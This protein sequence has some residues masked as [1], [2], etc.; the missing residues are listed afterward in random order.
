MLSFLGDWQVMPSPSATNTPRTEDSAGGES[1]GHRLAKAFDKVWHDGLKYK[2]LSLNLPDT[3][4]K[5]LCH[6]IQ[7]RKAKIKIKTYT[8]PEFPLNSGVPQGSSLSPTLY[9]IYTTDIP[10][11]QARCHQIMFADDITQ[12]ITNPNKSRQL[13]AI[14]TTREIEKINNFE[15]QWK[16]KTNPTKFQILHAAQRKASPIIIENNNIPY[17]Q[18]G[19]V[20]GLQ[21]K[22]T[23]IINHISQRKNYAKHQLIK[24][25]RFSSC[26]AHI[27]LKLYKTLIRPIL[28]YPPV[29]LN[30]IRPT[31]MLNLQT[32][33]NQALIWICG[34]RYPNPR[35]TI[36]TLHTTYNI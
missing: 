5:L 27:K 31:N 20:L 2:L 35:P 28:E 7:N 36:E 1:E 14:Q 25:R 4:T 32:I 3:I 24:L 11:P 21:I 12:I 17:S 13:M 22:T 15:K 30:T 9:I 33:Q 18:E 34:I 10:E 29:P 23:G 26:P 8:G 6:F 19:K 16:I